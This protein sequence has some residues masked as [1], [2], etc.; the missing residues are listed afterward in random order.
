[1]LYFARISVLHAFSGGTSFG[2]QLLRDQRIGLGGRVRMSLES[3]DCA[4]LS[5]EFK[6]SHCCA[7]WELRVSVSNVL[8]GRPAFIQ[9]QQA[10]AANGSCVALEDRSAIEAAFAASFRKTGS[11]RSIEARVCASAL[12]QTSSSL[13]AKKL[14]AVR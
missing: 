1:M 6:R 10:I 3:I 14:I 9:F 7:A 4:S 13:K 11:N 8:F 2:S 12:G 5:A